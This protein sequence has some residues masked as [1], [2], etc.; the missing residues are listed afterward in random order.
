MSINNELVTY[1][2]AQ[3]KHEIDMEIIKDLYDKATSP[4]K[5][6]NRTAPQAVSLVDHYNS[7]PIALTEVGNAMYF[8]TKMARP[9]FY[10]LGEDASNV[11]ESLPRF[12]SAGAVDPKGPYLAGYLGDI[13][14]Y[15]S[16]SIPVDG[17]L[18]GYKGA[19]LFDSGYIYAPYMPIMTTQLLMDET[20]T[21]RQGFAS[22][23]GK[24]MTNS[25]F[26]SANKI[27]TN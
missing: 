3:I 2:A 19:S 15:K 7:F 10:V 12:K 9:N 25:D 13:P 6:W 11:V 1:S 14:V 26:Y 21:G 4:S 16:P 17:Y 22:S 23:Y 24:R 20:F 18:A 5:S 27:T 8:N